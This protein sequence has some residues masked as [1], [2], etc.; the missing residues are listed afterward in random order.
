MLV[1]DLFYLHWHKIS[2]FS[3]AYP[4]ARKA[5]ELELFL[6]H[7][8]EI[9]LNGDRL[10]V[11]FELLHIGRP[12]ETIAADGGNVGLPRVRHLLN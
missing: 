4:D 8:L 3:A 11:A 1:D 5:R 10:A 6:Q 12:F 9:L 2:L 7:I